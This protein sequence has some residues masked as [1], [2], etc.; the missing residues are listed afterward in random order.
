MANQ[1][2]ICPVKKWLIFLDFVIVKV[3]GSLFL[4]CIRL[5][6]VFF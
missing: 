3:L 1:K 5:I 6:M 4:V 2:G